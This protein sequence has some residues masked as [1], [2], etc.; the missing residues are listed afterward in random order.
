MNRRNI[1]GLKFKQLSRTVPGMHAS[2][3]CSEAL[4]QHQEP[5]GTGA[6]RARMAAILYIEEDQ[7]DELETAVEKASGNSGLEKSFQ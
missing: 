1:K 4:E 2:W 6:Q 5:T 3:Q 7:F